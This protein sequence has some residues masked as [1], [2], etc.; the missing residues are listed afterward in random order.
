ML[1]S[2]MNARALFWILVV[3][4]PSSIACASWNSATYPGPGLDGSEG[5]TYSLDNTFS[6]KRVHV[7]KIDL[8]HP[9]VKLRGSTSSEKGLTPSEFSKKTGAVAA[10]NG[11]FFD[12]MLQPIGLAAGLGEAWPKSVDT[13]EWSFLACTD[14]NEC[15]I[16]EYNKVTPWRA[17]WNTVVGGWQI[18]LD[19]NFEWTSA[20]DTSCGDFCKVPHPRTAV[21]LSAD[22]K[23]MWW[24]MVEGRQGS[25]TGLTLSDTTRVFKRLG[26]EWALNLDGGGSSGMI[27]NGRRINGRPL[28]EPMERR[29]ANCLGVLTTG[30]ENQP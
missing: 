28:N 21:G 5:L 16:E 29:V 7:L 1:I 12:G 13:K 15:I 26:A 17:D 24:V 3:A 19:Q 14:K 25:L 6:N 11:D 10:I 23:T 30:A 27:L 4:M 20:Y 18:L 9:S 8:T 22:R 2:K